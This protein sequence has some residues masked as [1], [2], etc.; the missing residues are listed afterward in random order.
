LK[1]LARFGTVGASGFVVN[2]VALAFFVSMFH[3]NYLVGAIAATQV[4]TLWNFTLVELWA[5]RDLDARRSR[6][7][8]LL[9][10]L[11][12]NNAALLLRG[13]ILVVLT[14]GLRLNYL[15]SNIISL[16]V[17][18]LVRFAIADSW[19]W[20]GRPS[21]A[22]AAHD[23]TGPPTDPDHDA[24]VT[25]ASEVTAAS[26]PGVELIDDVEL[27]GDVEPQP[28]PDRF[29]RVQARDDV[30][31][32]LSDQPI[33]RVPG[34]PAAAG[35]TAL[36]VSEPEIDEAPAAVATGARVMAW[37]WPVAI[38]AVAVVVRVWELDRIGF[39]SDEVVYSSQAA[40]LA[41]KGHPELFTLFR[42]HPLAFQGLLS[43][44]YRVSMSDY[45]ARM[46]SVAFGIGTVWAGFWAARQ[47]YTRRVALI[48]AAILAVMPYMVVVNRQ[49]LLDGPMVFF[50]TIA[51]G[52]TARFARTRD[53]AWLYGAAV[54]LGLTF[55]TK[56]TGILLAG[57]MYTFII[58]T[59]HLRVRTRDILLSGAIL[60]A[61]V[62]VFPLASALGKRSNTSE[63]FFLWQVVRRPNHGLTFYLDRVPEALGLVVVALAVIGLLA[64]RRD[65]TWRESLLLC[66]IVVPTVFFVLWPVK[67]Y[68]YLLPIAPA[69][70]I[71]A[72]RPLATLP[73]RGHFR[74]HDLRVPAILV[75]TLVGALVALSLLVP[76]WEAITQSESI[77]VD[78][79]AG[80]SPGG[81]EA[82]RWI[83][84]TAPIG[85]KVITIGP[86]MSNLV[87]YFG[88]RESF[89]LS[90]SSN[91]LHR[92]PVYEPVANAD[93]RLRRGEIQYLV[94]DATSASRAP[95]FASQL[96]HLAH[97]YHGRVVH[98]EKVGPRDA[99][100]VYQVRP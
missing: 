68:Q 96:L 61:F 42:A 3:L 35:A 55:L 14:S 38:T 98:R 51:L 7:H 66:W 92:N 21:H 27:I 45:L 57:A 53:P 40:L 91:P 79:G 65:R 63:Q 74:M 54:A 11:L 72:A 67:G 83:G 76:T 77:T 2:E 50:G 36:A 80:G 32:F 99:I 24:W 64:L 89:G 28:R 23:E 47:L 85:A 1:R 59:P 49:V 34:T 31:V 9:L 93:L 13:P 88:G 17:L 100:V 30:D 62:V 33:V 78:A 56:E 46:L 52:L 69:V 94:W 86:S 71:L 5:F 18:T 82:G 70:A 60:F 95:G 12:V 4:S 37:V 25:L 19:I 81:R 73:L 58:L 39:N 26:L 16:G 15:V 41:G 43:L 22:P 75:T 87:R 48:V 20:S 10:F 44:V 8:R 84:A 97:R 6:A 29:V 90:V